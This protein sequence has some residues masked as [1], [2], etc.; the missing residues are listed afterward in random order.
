MSLAIPVDQAARGTH[1][2]AARERQFA[3]DQVDRL[4]A[5]GAFVDLCDAGVAIVLGGAG[6]ANNETV[7]TLLQYSI[8]SFLISGFIS[9][10]KISHP[11]EYLRAE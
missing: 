11:V 4:N 1:R 6:R 10:R 8:A 2:R 3:R 7:E 9:L 5:V